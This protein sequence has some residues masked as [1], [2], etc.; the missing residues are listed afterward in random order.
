MNIQRL[1]ASTLEMTHLC[2]LAPMDEFRGDRCE[3]CIVIKVLRHNFHN[4]GCFDD[5]EVG[6]IVMPNSHTLSPI[7]RMIALVPENV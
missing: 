3:K 2:S 6:R 4:N 5:F 7:V 1:I